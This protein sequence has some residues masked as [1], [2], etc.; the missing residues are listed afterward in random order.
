MSD[1]TVTLRRADDEDLAYVGTLLERDDLPAGDLGTA[2]ARFYV[3][4]DGDDRV[5]GGGI[6]QYGSDGLLRSVVVEERARGSGVGTALC[7]AL[8]AAARDG[9]VE[10]LYLLTTTAAGFFAGRGYERIDRDDVPATIGRT[11]EFSELC[12]ATAVCMR[13]SL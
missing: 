12:P 7:E 5:G 3:A 6:E 4:W 13:T 8:E 10:T 11:T 1:R 2:P 9:G